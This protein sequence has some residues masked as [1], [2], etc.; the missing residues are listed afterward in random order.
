[1]TRFKGYRLNEYP[2]VSQVAFPVEIGVA[3]AVCGSEC[4]VREFIVDGQTQVCQSCGR[5]MFRTKV[6][7]YV[8]PQRQVRMS[9]GPRKSAATPRPRGRTQPSTRRGKEPRA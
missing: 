4:G 7:R 5:L 2:K 8:L 6:K 1:M 9:S 3:Y